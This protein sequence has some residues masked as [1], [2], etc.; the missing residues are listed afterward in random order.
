DKTSE[1]AYP[2]LVRNE[3][4]LVSEI[5]SP[6]VY[7]GKGAFLSLMASPIYDS[8]GRV[9][10]AIGSIRDIT[11][12]KIAESALRE[13]E[14]RFQRAE[15]I[16]H[17]GHWQLD[18]VSGI[19]TSSEGAGA[20]YG[21][22]DLTISTAQKIPLPEYRQ[23]LD[24]ALQSLITEG[25]PYDLEYK[26]RRANDW[27]PRD[28]HSVA[29][30]DAEHRIVFGVIQDITDRKQFE[31]KLQATNEQLSATQDELRDRWQK[32]EEITAGVPGIVYQY[33]VRPNGEKGAYYI[34]E[35]A[36]E[37][38]LGFD[39]SDKDFFRWFTLHVHPDDR[40]RFL[41]SIDD[42]QKK[43][44]PWFFE[45]RFVKPSGET[46]WFCGRGN[47]AAH[48]DE[49]VCTGVFL[50]IT[51]KKTTEIT[52]RE[53]EEKFLSL[54]EH[55]PESILIIDVQGTIL[56]ANNAAVQIIGAHDRA[57]L[58]D[59]NLME[60]IAQESREDAARDFTQLSM[61]HDACPVP[62]SVISAQGKKIQMER[63]GKALVY[64]GKTANL[65]SVRSIT[66]RER[67][68]DAPQEGGEQIL[69]HFN[70][71]DAGWALHEIILNADKTASDYRVLAVNDSFEQQLGISRTAVIG[72]TSREAYNTK[73]PLYLD[74]FAQV[75]D[76]GE[77]ETFE[78][79][80][81]TFQKHFRISVYSPR[82]NQF[83]TVFYDITDRKQAEEALRQANIQLNLLTSITRHDILN[84]VSTLIGYLG[85]LRMK[86]PNPALT[87]YIS[88][89]EDTAVA[90]QCLITDTQTCQ[91][92]GL[93]APQWQDPDKLIRHLHFPETVALTLDL[94]GA[95]IYADPMLEKVFFNL[96]DNSIRHGRQ[97]TGIRVSSRRSNEGLVVVWEDNGAG[98]PIEEKDKIFEKGYG[99]NTGLGLFLCREILA[100]TGMTMRETGEP[101]KG[102]R[103]EIMIPKGA[104]RPS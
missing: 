13:S 50:D 7:G 59:R 94:Q 25:K 38:I 6:T 83:A 2:N 30:Y 40:N 51:E 35:R 26:I 65:L 45:G 98:I 88:K 46:I 28:I 89:L 81:S 84:K 92:L 99:K 82:K 86:F 34:N 22:K 12:Q 21:M 79:C 74:I 41:E 20:I 8:G 63:I 49:L 24:G 32:I 87:D 61:G 104:Y 36:G 11:P 3:D 48:R 103:F 93:R 73:E 56:F 54:A 62:L 68:E 75:A 33:Y 101:G 31:L 60:F 69:L 39:Y 55:S 15:T 29:A 47:P 14:A 10:G 37:I 95:E 19:M 64:E 52:L 58:A 16:A 78:T 90:I 96:L 100:I 43:V 102:A 71:L 66:D 57:A 44:V 76:S 53:S 27:A 1:N 91:N 67:L 80:S 9:T 42:S 70:N 77:P 85:I 18:L 72:K 5:Y 23:V 97:V 4:R 17:L